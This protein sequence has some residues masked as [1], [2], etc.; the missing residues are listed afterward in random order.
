MCRRPPGGIMCMVD[1]PGREKR[2][3]K[4]G[5]G[6]PVSAEEKEKNKALDRKFFE[7][8]WGKGNLAAVDEFIAT[9]YVMHPIPSGLLPGPEGTKQ[10]ITTYRTAFL[11][12]RSP[13]TTSSLQMIRWRCAGAFA[14]S[15]WETG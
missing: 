2:V 7:E 13:S 1:S 4:E 8:A 6:A 9:D 10:A 3:G 11:T 5:K 15:T 12:C 14:A